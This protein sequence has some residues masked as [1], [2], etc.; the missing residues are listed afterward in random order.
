MLQVTVDPRIHPSLRTVWKKDEIPF[1]KGGRIY[2]SNE[3]LTIV[4]TEKKDEGIYT[5]EVHTEYDQVTSSGRLTVL[6]E[7]PTFTSTPIDIRVLEGRNTLLIC[8]AAGIPQPIVKWKFKGKTLESKNGR[9]ELESVG[10]N[11][12]GSYVCTAENTYGSRLPTFCL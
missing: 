8:Q 4:N 5:C 7:A 9:L 6:N 11:Q 2:W 3:G 10:R 12:E 1:E